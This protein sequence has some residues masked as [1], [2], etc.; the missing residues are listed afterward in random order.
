MSML[1]Y[2]VISFKA[3]ED[4]KGLKFKFDT[5]FTWYILVNSFDFALEA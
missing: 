3:Q 4:K 2:I 1:A 5:D